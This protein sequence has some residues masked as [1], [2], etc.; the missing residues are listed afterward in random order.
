MTTLSIA[1]I[2]DLLPVG[3]MCRLP[4]IQGLKFESYLVKD[5]GAH[6]LVIQAKTHPTD[7]FHWHGGEFRNDVVDLNEVDFSREDIEVLS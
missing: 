5:H 7:A 4:G 2:K 1:Q 6:T 3:T